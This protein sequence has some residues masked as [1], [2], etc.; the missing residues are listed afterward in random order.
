MIDGNMAAIN[1]Y[2]DE[3]DRYEKALPHCS[4]CGDPMQECY[5]EFQGAK[6]CP[7]CLNDYKKEVCDERSL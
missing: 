5:Y 7:N 3:Q 4:D 1:K 6:I 2:L